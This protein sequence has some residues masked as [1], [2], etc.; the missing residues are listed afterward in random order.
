M[1]LPSSLGVLSA[2]RLSQLV[3]YM[4]VCLSCLV[5]VLYAFSVYVL[6]NQVDFDRSPFCRERD[7]LPPM[8]K[9]GSSEES[10]T[11]VMSIYYFLLTFPGVGI[12][13][14]VAMKSGCRNIPPGVYLCC[15]DTQ[16]KAWCR[17]MLYVVCKTGHKPCLLP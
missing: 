17:N 3:L 16:S 13:A 1:S 15:C 4:S 9:R 14:C 2:S 5:C 8:L 10:V 7:E 12:L 6:L 11:S